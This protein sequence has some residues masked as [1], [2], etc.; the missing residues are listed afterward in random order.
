M[1]PVIIFVVQFSEITGVTDQ[2]WMHKPYNNNEN[3]HHHSHRP[4]DGMLILIPV[5]PNQLNSKC[6]RAGSFEACW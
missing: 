6:R 3:H 4:I 1:F 2:Q 5:F